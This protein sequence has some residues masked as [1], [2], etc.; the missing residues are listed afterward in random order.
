[1]GHARVGGARP[2]ATR[3]RLCSRRRLQARRWV[4]HLRMGASP[5]TSIAIAKLNSATDI[6][7]VLPAIRVPTLIIQRSGDKVIRVE[8]GRYLAAHIPGATY[9]EL[10]GDEHLPF[11]GHQDEILTPVQQFLGAGRAAAEPDTVLTTVLAMEIAERAQLM[12]NV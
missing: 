3:A 2:G 8:G 5:G 7:H 1:M 10:P 4:T 6:R 11:L 12:A 9:V